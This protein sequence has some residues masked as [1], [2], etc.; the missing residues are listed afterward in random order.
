ML[1]KVRVVE[2]CGKTAPFARGFLAADLIRP[3]TEICERSHA[4]T[5]VK[6]H[7]PCRFVI[8]VNALKNHMRS[9]RV[10]ANFVETECLITVCYVS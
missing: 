4:N 2:D 1:R 6:M 9:L 3:N 5:V 7:L 10:K 8:L